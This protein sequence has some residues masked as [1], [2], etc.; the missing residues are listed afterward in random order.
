MWQSFLKEKLSFIFF[1]SSSS[2]L[3]QKLPFGRW[4]ACVQQKWAFFFCFSKKQNTPFLPFFFS[5]TTFVPHNGASLLCQCDTDAGMCINKLMVQAAPSCS[6]A[7]RASLC[8]R[9]PPHPCERGPCGEPLQLQVSQQVTTVCLRV[10][11][12]VA[13]HRVNEPDVPV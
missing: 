2:F 7:S 4:Q 3:S 1:L 6:T 12:G 13:S 10:A 11:E 5:F 9:P 8:P